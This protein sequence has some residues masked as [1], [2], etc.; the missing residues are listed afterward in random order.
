MDDT[1]LTLLTVDTTDT[2]RLDFFCMETNWQ[3]LPRDTTT[4]NNYAKQRLN[5]EAAG[6]RL[7]LIRKASKNESKSEFIKTLL[8]IKILLRI[9]SVT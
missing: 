1:L 6:I 8:L 9:Q 7:S 4:V 3:A 2:L 5:N